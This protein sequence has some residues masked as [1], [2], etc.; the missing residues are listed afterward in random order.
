MQ[1]K[2]LRPALTP[3]TSVRSLLHMTE[4]WSRPNLTEGQ[5]ALIKDAVGSFNAILE[6]SPALRERPGQKEMVH[7]VAST[8]ALAKPAKNSKNSQVSDQAEQGASAAGPDDALVPPG[9]FITVIEAGTGVGKSLGYSVPAIVTALKRNK[10]VL[11]STGTVALQE[12]LVAKD[13]PAVTAALEKHAGLKAKFVLAK[14]RS[15]YLCNL[16]LKK[17]LG[18]ESM[19]ASLFDGIDDGESPLDGSVVAP[20][21]AEADFETSSAPDALPAS[22][23]GSAMPRPPRIF[24]AQSDTRQIKFFES[25]DKSLK[26][27]EWAGDRDSLIEQPDAGDWK[28]VAADSH[29]CTGRKCHLYNDCTLYRARREMAE[30]NVIVVNHDLLLSSLGTRTLP[31]LKDCLLVLDEAHNLP[32]TARDHFSGVLEL[33]RTKWM[34]DLARRM[35]KSASL[36][37]DAE[38]SLA[39]QAAVSAMRRLK[40]QLQELQAQARD[41]FDPLMRPK[42]NPGAASPRTSPGKANTVGTVLLPDGALPANLTEPMK[43][44]RGELRTVLSGLKALASEVQVQL[45]AGS[46][47]P[48]PLNEIYQQLGSLASRPEDAADAI[49]M[50]LA[51][52][53]AP[54]A[55]WAQAQDVNGIMVLQLHACPLSAEG[56]MNPLARHLWSKVETAIATSA[57][58]ATC[59]DFGFYLREAGLSHLAQVQTLKVASPFD[60]PTQGSFTVVQTEH[61]PKQQDAYEREVANEMLIDMGNITSGALVLFASRRHMDLTF[62]AIPDN[63]RDRVVLRQG[64]LSRAQLLKLHKERVD[65]GKASIILGLQSF[66][67][68]LDLPGAYCETLMIA[69]LPF[70]P[71]TDMVSQASARWLRRLGRDAF[72]EQVVPLAAMKLQQWVGRAIRTETDHAEIYCYDA[73]LLNTQFGREI[74]AGLPAFKRMERIAD[75]TAEL[76]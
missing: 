66:G 48:K 13:L 1:S 22:A 41:L 50:L 56:E 76:S 74:L 23:F 61:T 26:S 54:H 42:H 15:R 29:S 5:S 68:G 33:S 3:A 12:Q 4:H 60:Y 19:S 16:K 49:E 53:D 6:G 55:K 18:Q 27:G 20:L 73:R 51:M 24:P 47:D 38:T 40:S 44:A 35:L 58:L 72:T 64:D 8:F 31:A 14:G 67:E 63:I 21:E 36:L 37:K 10:R 9:P 57:T 25:L 70:A 46:E 59:G 17:A 75:M 11:I 43:L 71:P 28:A 62:E 30:A 65:A 7:A 2:L 32:E 34:D 52:S 45:A 69:K 39:T